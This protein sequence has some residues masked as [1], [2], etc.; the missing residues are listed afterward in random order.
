MFEYK[1]KVNEFKGLIRSFANL[2]FPALELENSP[3]EKNWVISNIFKFNSNPDEHYASLPGSES[4]LPFVQFYWPENKIILT[5]YSI[6][7]HND[8][9]YILRSWNISVSN[10][11]TNWMVID[12]HKGINDLSNGN[13]KTF[14]ISNVGNI[15]YSY[16]KIMMTGVDNENKYVL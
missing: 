12:Y 5:A 11:G 1:V 4:E 16:I 8:N 13:T 7:S 6:N 10:D 9:R 14:Y 15:A 3:N 2:D